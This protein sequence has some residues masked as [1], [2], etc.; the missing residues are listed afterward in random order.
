MLPRHQ[1]VI[2]EKYFSVL[3][4]LG[5][6]LGCF[7]FQFGNKRFR[8]IEWQQPQWPWLPLLFYIEDH[9]GLGV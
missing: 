5:F 3:V 7:I 2:C 8:G 4:K 9:G 6:V 1:Q